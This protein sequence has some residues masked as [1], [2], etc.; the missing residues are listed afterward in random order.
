MRY[1]QTL[2]LLQNQVSL[3]R[4]SFTHQHFTIISH[5]QNTSS[6]S[7]VSKRNFNPRTSGNSLYET[8]R[9]CF[10]HR[11]VC[12]LIVWSSLVTKG[13]NY[14]WHNGKEGL[15]RYHVAGEMTPKIRESGEQENCNLGTLVGSRLEGHKM[16]KEYLR[17]S[18][19]TKQFKSCRQK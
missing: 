19:C 16:L 7:S 17:R 2:A 18:L 4:S 1:S 12:K 10:Y 3:A 8:K 13:E 15:Y 11:K 6:R 14:A 5:L 9:N